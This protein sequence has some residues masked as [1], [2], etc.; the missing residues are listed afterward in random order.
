MHNRSAYSCHVTT[1]VFFYCYNRTANFC[2]VA[3]TVN[4]KIVSKT[5]V[6]ENTLYSQNWLYLM[7]IHAMYLSY[8]Q[9][10]I[11][12]YLKG[13]DRLLLPKSNTVI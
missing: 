11:F 5:S 7:R 6:F 9:K 2:V 8:Y 3:V 10:I 13:K 12:I 1:T 4:F